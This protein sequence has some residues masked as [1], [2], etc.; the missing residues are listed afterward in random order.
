MTSSSFAGLFLEPFYQRRVQV[1]RRQ[2]ARAVAR[3]NARF[4]DVLHDARHHH[5]LT[6]RDGVH[7][8]LDGGLEE[9]VDQHRMFGRRLDRVGHI[10]G[11]LFLAVDNFHRPPAEHE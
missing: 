10:P 3:M 7:V 9:L 4:L 1:V 6:I 11:Q 8:D 5:R 2:D